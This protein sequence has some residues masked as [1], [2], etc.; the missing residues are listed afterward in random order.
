MPLFDVINCLEKNNQNFS[1]I[2]FVRIFKQSSRLEVVWMN[3]TDGHM[4]L[5]TS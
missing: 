5:Q 1:P 4:C 2:V 3:P